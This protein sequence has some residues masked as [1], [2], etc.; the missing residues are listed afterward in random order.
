MGDSES[1]VIVGA[2]MAGAKG[3]EALRDQGFDGRITLLGDEAHR[4]YERP[5]LSKEYLM[6]GAEFDAAY[7]H[8]ETWY[9][10]NRVDLRL[11]TS[12]RRIDRSLRQVELADGTRLEFDKLMLATGAQPRSIPV[13]GHDAEGVLHL[14]RVGDSDR[15]KDVLAG[16]EDLV[17]VGAGWIGLE[18]AAAARQAGVGVTV[19]ETAELPLLQVLGREVAEVFAAMHREQGVSFRFTTAIDEIL[20]PSGKVTGVR[21]TDG[22]EIDAQAVLIAVGADPDVELAAEAKLR[23]SNGVLVDATLRTGDPNIVAAGDVANAFHPLL[24]KQIR[25]EHWN[26]AL[27]QPAVAASSMLGGDTSY[28]ELPYFF[29]DQYD[30]GMEYLGFVEPGEYDEV[31]FRGDVEAREFIAFWLSEGRVLAGMNV[32]IWDV[33]EQIKTLITSG[34]TIDRQ[35]LGD[36]GV[37]LNEHIAR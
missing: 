14:R 16:I 34:T 32:N 9:A 19:V 2:G 5:P 8:P 15:I 26:N 17:V 3:A 10:D 27:N 25:V 6:G 4:P 23:V 36:P 30:L 13:P 35:A 1:F 22:L 28:S 31:L 29:T 11:N 18:V 12:A 7:V 37:P 21:L 20:A 33:T 24:G